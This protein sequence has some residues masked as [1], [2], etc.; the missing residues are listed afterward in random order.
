MHD[1]NWVCNGVLQVQNMHKIGPKCVWC[2]SYL[3]PLDP[4]MHVLD[5]ICNG[6]LQEQ[7]IHKMEPK[8][9]WASSIF[10]L[11]NQGQTRG[12]KEVGRTLL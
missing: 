8:C 9:I 11:T 6:V 1:L 5:W 2:C 3:H 10:F 12:K 7:K 4:V